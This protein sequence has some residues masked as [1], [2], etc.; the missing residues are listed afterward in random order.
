VHHSRGERCFPLALCVTAS[1]GVSD[2][3]DKLGTVQSDLEQVKSDAKSEF[4]SQIDAVD[5]AL[6]TLKTSMDSAV[7]D[8][9]AASLAAVVAAAPAVS[10]SAQTLVSDVMATC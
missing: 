7:A 9:T 1:N 10:S 6:A 5:A 4:S 2:L 3:Q 8:P